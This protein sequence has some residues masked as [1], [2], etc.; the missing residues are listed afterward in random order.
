MICLSVHAKARSCRPPRVRTLPRQTGHAR[1]AHAETLERDHRAL[2]GH[3]HEHESDSRYTQHNAERAAHTHEDPQRNKTHERRSREHVTLK[4]TLKLTSD[5]SKLQEG[6][7][8]Y[9]SAGWQ[10][11]PV[12]CWADATADLDYHGDIKPTHDRAP[13][14]ACQHQKLAL[15][16]TICLCQHQAI[17]HTERVEENGLPLRCSCRSE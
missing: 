5:A 16:S 15:K 8:A 3:G 12:T 6:S 2:Q 4:S 10:W 1:V 17:V 13:C 14:D 9:L 11:F 7:C